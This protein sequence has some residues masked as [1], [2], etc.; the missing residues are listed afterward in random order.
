MRVAPRARGGTLVRVPTYREQIQEYI[1]SQ[2]RPED[3]FSHQPRL[4][5]LARELA[6][7]NPYDDDVLH[8]AAWMH[9]LGVFIG[10]RPEEPAELAAWDHLA[11]TMQRTPELLRGFGFP[12]QKIPGVVEVIRTHQPSATPT[13]FEGVLLRDADI[14]EQLGA[15]AVLRTVSK[16][17]RDTR[18][19]RFDDALRLLRKNVEALP[20]KLVLDSARVLARARVAALRAFLAAAEEETGAIEF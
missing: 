15:I 7:E 18:F 9:D 8:A 13:C 20:G 11:Y 16:I 5:R 3:K 2:A 17:G 6:G 19:A 4:Y 10:H 1:R 12:R 14:L